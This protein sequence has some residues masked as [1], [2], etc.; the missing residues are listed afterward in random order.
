[1]YDIVS[2]KIVEYKRVFETDDKGVEKYKC[3]VLTIEHESKLGR[4]YT[5]TRIVS[6]HSKR[7]YK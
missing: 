2:N 5:R 7:K 3:L 6:L 4:K 1:M